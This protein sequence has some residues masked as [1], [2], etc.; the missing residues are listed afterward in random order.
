RKLAAAKTEEAK[1]QL[2]EARQK[3]ATQASDA[4]TQLDA[5]KADAAAKL[6]AVASTKEAAKVAA[7]RK[8]DAT[9]AA[10]DAQLATEPVSVYISRSTQ[11]VYVRRNT[12][13]PARDGGGEVFD[14]S[15]EAPV[16]I[17]DPER[18][19]GTH[20]FTAVAQGNAGLRWTAVTIDDGDDAKDALDRITIPKQV[21]DR[22]APTAVPR[23]SIIVSDEPLSSETNYRTEFVA[24]LSNQ[25]QGGFVTRKPTTN[26][27]VV[28]SGD[29][30]DDGFGNVFQRSWDGQPITQPRRRGPPPTYFRPVQ[31]GWW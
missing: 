29:E 16:E 31:P 25:P 6:A 7:A 23:S 12:H 4:A 15:I 20:I 2:A 14:T 13:K 30:Y 19:I 10:T 22:I 28:A 21:L 11:M 1:A 9:K 18:P 24:V 27:D 5:A 17:R 26:V 3:L 8:A